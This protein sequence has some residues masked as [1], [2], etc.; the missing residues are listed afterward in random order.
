[1]DLAVVPLTR[2]EYA[3]DF[4]FEPVHL[5]DLTPKYQAVLVPLDG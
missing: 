4:L 2:S 1:M 5:R 3:L